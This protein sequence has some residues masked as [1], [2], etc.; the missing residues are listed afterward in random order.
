MKNQFIKYCTSIG[1]KKHSKILI[2]VS[3]GLD[4][5]AL[6]QLFHGT[7]YFIEVVHC[8][9]NLRGD[10][11]VKDAMMV[12]ILCQD[13]G[14]VCHVK[15]FDTKKYSEDK[16][17]SIQMA[18]RDLRYQWFEALRLERKF[19]YIATAHHQDDQVETL[20]INL[21]RGTGIDGLKGIQAIRNVLIRPLLFCNRSELQDWMQLHEYPFREDQT[22]YSLL[23]LRNKIRYQVI[24]LLHE[25]N[26]SISKTFQQNAERISCS[27]ENLS[28]FYEQYRK[29]VIQI[30]GD[31]THLI[32]HELNKF[33]SP[34][35]AIFYFISEFGF[36]DWDAISKLIIGQSGKIIFSSSHQLL[37][38]R[39]SIVLREIK[40]NHKKNYFIDQSSTSISNPRKIHFQIIYID[41]FEMTTSLN[42]AALDFHKLTFPLILRKWKKGDSFRPLGMKGDKK[43]SD[44]FIDLKLSVFEKENVL[45]LCSQDQIV[46]VLGHRIDDRFKLVKNTQKVYLVKLN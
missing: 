30:N 12:R 24:P 32:L 22:N 4:S 35:S 10:E 45:L 6:L 29:K 14:I 3:G 13:L 42:Q 40:K 36:S 9:F 18:A 39:D 16:K 25:V 20:L 11:S 43:L 1:L 8:N 2:A 41:Q 21:I 23:Y 37:K 44:F 38:N 33:P 19:D 46:W 27:V 28:F 26:P 17:I 34:I 7:G 31:Q 15:E 5:M